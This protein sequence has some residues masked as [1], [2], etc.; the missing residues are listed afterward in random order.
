MADKPVNQYVP[1]RENYQNH[2]QWQDSVNLHLGMQNLQAAHAE[3]QKKV[4]EA[5]KPKPTPKP[6][7][8]DIQGIPIKGATDPS[9]TTL[10]LTTGSIKNGDTLRFNSATGNFEFGT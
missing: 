2:Q 10:S 7:T 9:T 4:A 1:Q 5:S 6:F 3:T 8:G